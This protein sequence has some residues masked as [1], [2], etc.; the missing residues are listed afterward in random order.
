MIVYRG[1]KYDVK[2]LLTISQRE[3]LDGIVI[4][5]TSCTCMYRKKRRDTREWFLDSDSDSMNN[6]C[7]RPIQTL[8]PLPH[9][10][11]NKTSVKS[12]PITRTLTQPNNHVDAIIHIHT[13][14]R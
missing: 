11:V 12:T 3:N 9:G 13:I 14:T 10:T 1:H 4:D 5:I 8:D 7:H 6:V 2:E